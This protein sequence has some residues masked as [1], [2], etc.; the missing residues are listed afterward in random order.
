MILSLKPSLCF[1]VTWFRNKA[2]EAKVKLRSGGVE[3]LSEYVVLN[4]GLSWKCHKLDLVNSSRA[5][6]TFSP[7]CFFNPFEG[8]H[9]IE[10]HLSSVNLMSTLKSKKR[11]EKDF[12]SCIIL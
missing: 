4:T 8:V 10:V 9:Q 3:G 12:F 7:F 5:V 11:I 1:L 6:M 2:R